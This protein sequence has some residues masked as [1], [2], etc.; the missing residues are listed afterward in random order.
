MR[1][2][3]CRPARPMY[4]GASFCILTRIEQ[5]YK[6]LNMRLTASKAD[7]NSIV[8]DRTTKAR[9]RDAA[10]ECLAEFGVGATTARKVAE[11]TGVSPGLVIHHFGTM[12]GLRSVCDEHIA[13]VIRGHKLEAMSAGPNLDVLA[14]F[15]NPDIGPLMS[16]LARVLAD[17]SPTVARLVDDLVDDAEGYIE[18][19]VESGMVRPT[20]DAR[21][22]AVVLTIWN[23]GALVL[24]EHLE[25]LVGVDLTD[26]DVLMDPSLA[27]YFGPMYQ[28]YGEGVFT[29]TFAAHVL[30][31]IAKMASEHDQMKSQSPGE[32]EPSRTTPSE[33]TP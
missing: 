12:E 16:Y 2:Q 29:E 28:I 26:P 1:T 14:A 30:E 5:P 7:D 20:A 11:R 17:D 32:A 23:L 4:A 31:A 19:G 21:G 24:H 13:A 8:D 15:R 9:I 27:S 3:R 22:R 10:I 25:R 33:G 6:L 18:Q